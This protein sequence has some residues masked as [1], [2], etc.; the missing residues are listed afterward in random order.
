MSE[1]EKRAQT[2]SQ[3][4]AERENSDGLEGRLVQAKAKI[5][6]VIAANVRR[7]QD[8]ELMHQVFLYLIVRET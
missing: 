2:I 3:L 8:L 7:N 4:D 1:R 5:E 6:S